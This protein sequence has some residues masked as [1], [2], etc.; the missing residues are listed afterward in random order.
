MLHSWAFLPL[1]AAVLSL[2][3]PG[4]RPTG[5]NRGLAARGRLPPDRQSASDPRLWHAPARY[6]WRVERRTDAE[7]I[8]DLV[9]AHRLVHSKW[10]DSAGCLRQ[11]RNRHPRSS[12]VDNNVWDAATATATFLFT[13]GGHLP[14]V[15]IT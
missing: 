9:A 6:E 2:R 13:A 3:R 5:S 8:P 12:A 15:P 14:R 4:Q 10:H 11:C 7:D 1:F